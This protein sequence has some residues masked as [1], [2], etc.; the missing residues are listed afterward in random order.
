MA[1]SPLLDEECRADLSP[2]TPGISDVPSRQRFGMVT[3]ARPRWGR[4]TAS[5]SAP[6]LR[7]GGFAGPSLSLMG[8]WDCSHVR[9]IGNNGGWCPGGC[10]R[11]GWE[12]HPLTPLCQL[13]HSGLT[14]GLG[15]DGTPVELSTLSS[16]SSPQLLCHSFS[17]RKSGITMFLG[18]QNPVGEW[19]YFGHQLWPQVQEPSVWDSQRMLAPRHTR[20]PHPPVPWIA[21]GDQPRCSF[22]GSHFRD[23][24][25]VLSHSALTKQCLASPPSRCLQQL[26]PPPRA[27]HPASWPL[28]RTLSIPTPK[29][30]VEG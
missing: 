20:C 29:L 26:C 22:A 18:V 6:A 16:V 3:A 25:G 19:P 23:H 15:G 28:N 8:I 27:P 4:G 5:P 7:A 30:Q 12:Q 9:S 17:I 2:P 24:T 13:P 11:L 10:P 14:D 21:P 1:C